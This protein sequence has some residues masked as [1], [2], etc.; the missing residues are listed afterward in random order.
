MFL[1]V[2]M[3]VLCIQGLSF[4]A[5]ADEVDEVYE[6]FTTRSSSTLYGNHGEIEIA[7]GEH[8]K[9]STNMSVDDDSNRAYFD[10]DGLW[11]WPYA[12]VTVTALNGETISKIEAHIGWMQK[13]ALPAVSSG[14]ISGY[15][16]VEHGSCDITVNDIN[17]SSVT[18]FEQTE[19]YD[20][21]TPPMYEISSWKIYYHTH[22]YAFSA[23]G[24]TISIT[25]DKAG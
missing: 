11:I 6:K 3:A 21:S 12:N 25:C 16:Y 2:C 15:T 24:D 13:D 4:R 7:A 22:D 10:E 1:C 20:I 9:I 5:A 23:E 17:A 18:F 8:F 19:F 14:T